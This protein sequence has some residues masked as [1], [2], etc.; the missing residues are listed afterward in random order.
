[1]GKK[2][3]NS[4]PEHIK[5]KLAIYKENLIEACCVEKLMLITL[6]ITTN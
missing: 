5:A 1:M 2:N 4:L 3:F 6:L